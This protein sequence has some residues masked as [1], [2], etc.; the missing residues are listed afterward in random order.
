[1]E[2]SARTSKAKEM[3]IAAEARRPCAF[4]FRGRSER[5]VECL[6]FVTDLGTRGAN[7]LCMQ[8]GSLD[9]LL[10]AWR[11]SKLR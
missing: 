8:G 5:T 4:I 3:L 1:M 10:C 11:I 6:K 9:V 2:K 7:K